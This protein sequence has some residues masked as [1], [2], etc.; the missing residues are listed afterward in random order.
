MTLVLTGFAAGLLAQFLTVYYHLEQALQPGKPG[1][2]QP[3]PLVYIG[4]GVIGAA[5]ALSSIPLMML[6]DYG[7]GRSG[8]ESLQTLTVGNLV[9]FGPLAAASVLL[10]AK[11]LELGDRRM[12][13][14]MLV[15]ASALWVLIALGVLLGR[16]E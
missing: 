13:S 3:V 11:F 8:S 10:M 12:R 1:Q 14:F 6:L 16:P 5:G 15:A 7:I 9:V 2:P 4:T